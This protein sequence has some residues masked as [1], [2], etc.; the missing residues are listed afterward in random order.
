MLAGERGGWW[1]REKGRGV[2]GEVVRWWGG[3][4]GFGVGM[5]MG[6]GDGE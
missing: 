4:W 5:D 3:I 2:G 6:G 1:G